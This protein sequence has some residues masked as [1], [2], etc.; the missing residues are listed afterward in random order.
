MTST[1]PAGPSPGQHPFRWVM[2]AGLWMVY[3]AFGMTTATIAPLAGP[4][5]DELGLSH[6][7]LGSAMGAWPLVYIFSAIPCGALLDRVGPWLSLTLA[8]ATIALSG[9]LRAT[10]GGYGDLFVAVALFGLGGP[11]VSVGAPKLISQWFAGQQRGLAMGIYVT[12]PA[13]G[14]VSTLSLTNSVLMPLTGGDWRGVLT[15]YAGVALAVGTTWFCI[16][17]SPAARRAE[18]A[19][20]RGGAPTNLSTFTG[21][22]KVPAIRI[23]L[24][25]AFSTFFF[26]HS[27]NNW[28]PE[29]L[30]AGGMSAS[31]AGFWAAVPSATGI[32]AALVIPRLAVPHRRLALLCT[33]FVGAGLATLLVRLEPGPLLGLGLV[34][35]GLIRGSLQSIMLLLVIDTREVSPAVMGAAGGLYFTAGE[36]GGVLGP[37]SIGF[38]RDL[39]GGFSAPLFLLTGIC[40]LML[41]LLGVLRRTLRQAA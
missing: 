34:F 39:S 23:I 12:G 18:R 36:I 24:L 16:G 13:L 27:L 4:I 7:A 29:I 35:Q 31:D 26:N 25:L 33:L 6:A 32:F 28:L 30:R 3:F 40:A 10:A 8:A 22:L 37:L 2:L 41:V 1:S 17:G 14:Q 20:T 19:V 38:T 21:L 9:L 15:I 5:A 11:L